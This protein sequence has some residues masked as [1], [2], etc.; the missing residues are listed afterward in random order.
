MNPLPGPWTA[1]E[2][3]VVIIAERSASEL[4]CQLGRT[5]QAVYKRRYRLRLRRTGIGE[6]PRAARTPARIKK[7]ARYREQGR[8]NLARHRTPW[9]EWEHDL[10]LAANRPTDLELSRVLGRTLQA[11]Q[12]KRHRLL[13]GSKRPLRR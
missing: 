8:S 3:R 5:V 6:S 1:E 2:D 12:N 7:E 4:A 10:I 13:Q 9:A 11:I